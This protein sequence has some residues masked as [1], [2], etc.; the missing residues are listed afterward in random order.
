MGYLPSIQAFPER[1]IITTATLLMSPSKI[2][3]V[4]ACKVK[5]IEDP[6]LHHVGWYQ[7]VL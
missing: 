5:H 6:F 7:V 1:L 3:N 4:A 2:S